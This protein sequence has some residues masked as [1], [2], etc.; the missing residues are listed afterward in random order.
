MVWHWLIVPYCFP[1]PIFWVVGHTRRKLP[2]PLNVI[3]VQLRSTYNI[4][5][6]DLVNETYPFFLL[7]SKKPTQPTIWTIWHDSDSSEMLLQ[8]SSLTFLVATFHQAHRHLS[9]SLCLDLLLFVHRRVAVLPHDRIN[10]F[11]LTWEGVSDV[12]LS[13]Q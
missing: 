4:A 1:I 13:M 9:L 6:A 12:N 11:L 8:R 10:F 2:L 7:A 3:T 5:K